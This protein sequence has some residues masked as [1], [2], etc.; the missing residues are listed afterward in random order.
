VQLL[1][2]K[3]ALIVEFEHLWVVHQERE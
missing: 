1:I 2:K 3:V